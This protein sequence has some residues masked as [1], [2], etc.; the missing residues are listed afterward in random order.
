[1]RQVPGL[2]SHLPRLR[3]A[4][5]FLCH[6]DCARSLGFAVAASRCAHIVGLRTPPNAHPGWP[7]PETVAAALK[8]RELDVSVRHGAVRISVH[9][10]ISWGD[11]DTLCEALVACIAS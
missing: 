8:A 4:A 9:V 10:Y 3:S 6:A 11:V 1:M 2:T 5:V 7:S